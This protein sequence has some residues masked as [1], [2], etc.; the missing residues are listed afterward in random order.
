M[1]KKFLFTWC[2]L[3]MNWVT[4]LAARTFTDA[5]GRQIEAELVAHSGENIVLEKSGK[6]FSVAIKS[7]SPSDQEYIRGWITE[8]PNAID[9]NYKFR[10]YGD[11]KSVKGVDQKDG[12][13]IDDKVK[14]SVNVCEM[15]VYNNGETPVSGI[16]IHYEI[17]IADY[18][19]MKDNQYAGLAVGENKRE[20]LEVIAGVSKDQ[21]IPV[22]GR[23]NLTS[24]FR[25]EAYIDRDGGKTD[26]VALDKVIGLKVRVYKAGQM[27]AEFTETEDSSRMPK[28]T[29]QEKPPGKQER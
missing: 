20:T 7:F 26:A 4:D 29:W 5:S 10:F 16:D 12:A 11:F 28:I 8:N 24:E 21:S 6:K 18:V 2:L 22:K 14:F 3:A 19:V 23:F 25:T 1:L 27:L 15:I 9:I 17:Y 13:M